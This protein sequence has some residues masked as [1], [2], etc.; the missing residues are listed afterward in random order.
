MAFKLSKADVERKDGYVAD[1]REA[2]GK[3]NDAVSTYN[4]EVTTRRAA[5]EA[6]VE[7]FN[8]ILGEAGGFCEDIA[9]EAESQIDDKSERW[10]QSET[11]QFAIAWKDAWH[12]I[13]LDLEPVEIEWPADLAVETEQMIADLENLETEKGE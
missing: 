7:A 12:Q 5:V 3:L 9:N 11:G 10:Q 8:E 6:A 4:T 1:L 13:S 2:E